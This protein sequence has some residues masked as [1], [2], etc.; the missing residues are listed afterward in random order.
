MDM[1]AQHHE[2]RLFF[3]TGRVQ[4][5][6]IEPVHALSLRPALLA[7][8]RD[9]TS[10]RQDYPLVLVGSG[11][12][13]GIVR[14]LPGIVD[15]LLLEVA[16][17]GIEGEKLRR[18]VL[19]LEREIRRLVGQGRTGRLLDVW[20]EAAA[21]VGKPGDPSV[22]GVLAA[23]GDKINLDGEVV[24]CTPA[25]VPKTLAHF[26]RA[27]Q[28]RKGRAF[29]D[30]AGRLIVKL[31][32]ILRAAFIRSEAGQSAGTLRAAVGDGHRGDFDF[33]VMSKLVAR[34]SPKD[35][36][37]PARRRR[38]EW[39]LAVLRQQPFYPDPRLADR[40]DAPP[41][42]AFAFDNCA[43]ALDAF[44]TRLPRLAE[45]VKAL[46][47]AELEADNRYVDA[48]DDPFF[49]HFD[50][51]AL[52]ADEIAMFPDYLV[53]IPPDRNDAPENASLMD[54]LSSG[55]PVKVL[56]QTSDLYEE[57]AIGAGHFAFGVRSVRLANT[58]T[59]LGGVY[60][61]QTTSANLPALRERVKK[62]FAHRGAGLFSVYAGAP[63]PAGDLPPYLTAAAAM[64]SRAF[65]AFAYDPHAGDDQASR[66]VLADN[67]QA[68]A[69]WPALP[70][71]YADE[72]GQRVQ[73][74]VAFTY[75][76]FV[77]CDR[78]YAKHFARVP[79]DRW[80]AAMIPAADWLR[81]DAKALEGLVPY[82]L[83]VDDDDVLQRVI[84]DQRLM[85]AAIRCR[86]LWH[87]LQEQGGIH[88][89][90]AERLLAQERATWEARARELEQKAAAP[91]PAD[92]AAP[93]AAPA[94]GAAPAAAPAEPAATAAPERNPDEAWIETSRCPSCNECQLINDKM[95]VYNDNKQAYIKDVKLGTFRQ[96]VEAA[97][98]CQV[99]IIHP[100]KPWNPDEPGLPE[101]IERAKTFQ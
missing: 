17:R 53:C 70:F 78:R 2:Q 61:V 98:S 22:E 99:S 55:L 86:T 85:H 59:G 19:R 12:Q 96:L 65:P 14:S 95:F 76:D 7:R 16:P 11:P 37:S 10:L 45:V 42:F 3:S 97:E 32:D 74:D 77:L 49:E 66:F 82:V 81:R 29:R 56:V 28:D 79:R 57:A 62:G 38:I 52:S 34:R 63:A 60:V 83:A 92:A 87:R 20:A 27:E 93:T 88:N 36:L 39:A 33:A 8:Y 5:E 40:P 71:A 46:A 84:V 4:G 58:A 30:T 6:G 94:A 47:V 18:H 41:A 44:R 54:M 9:L 75:I 80:N 1:A 35:E 51:S 31:S 23:I 100:G 48:K 90:H 91:A 43:A 13:K 64:E 72:Q 73:E 68:D 26:W 25:G 67:P 69:D 50:E 15:D 24:D 89:S 101:L 21:R